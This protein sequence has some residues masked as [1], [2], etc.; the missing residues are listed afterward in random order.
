MPGSSINSSEILEIIVVRAA[1]GRHITTRLSGKVCEREDLVMYD[2]HFASPFRNMAFP[3]RSMSPSEWKIAIKDLTEFY[4]RQSGW[5]IWSAFP[6]DLHEYGFRL[7]VDDPIMVR[8]DQ[9][10]LIE[11][12]HSQLVYKEVKDNNGMRLFEG[13][14]EAAYGRK[15]P[16]ENGWNG[17]VDGRVLCEELRYWL[18]YYDEEPV[19]T[20]SIFNYNGISTVKNISTLPKFRGRQFGTC[21]SIHAI[22]HC[23]HK[24]TLDGDPAAVNIYRRL[25]FKEIGRMLFWQYKNE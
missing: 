3:N 10:L 13:I 24:A 18:G 25:G 15:T 19:A 20:G 23:I 16:A 7:A 22:N 17:Y 11:P 14:R 6:D 12:M 9:T 8:T 2:G 21:M 1:Y 5:T 4:G